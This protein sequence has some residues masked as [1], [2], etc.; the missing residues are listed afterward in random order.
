MAMLE[1]LAMKP[2][3][4]VPPYLYMIARRLCRRGLAVFANGTWYATSKGIS[5]TGRTLH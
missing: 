5:V 3:S 4:C 1:L 2:L